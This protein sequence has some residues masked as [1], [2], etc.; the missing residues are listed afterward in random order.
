MKELFRKTAAVLL[1][2]IMLGSTMSWTVE[3]HYCMGRLVDIALFNE[4]GNCGMAMGL[5]GSSSDM[6]PE[7]SCCDDEIIVIDGQD[8]L[9]LDFNSI[10]L[11]EQTALTLLSFAWIA[12]FED[13]PSQTPIRHINPPPILVRDIQLLD[14]VFLI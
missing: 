4:A 9:K 5:E 11:P 14:Q 13:Y 6:L 7:M 2:L 10:E 12:L 8:Q 1:T 3:K